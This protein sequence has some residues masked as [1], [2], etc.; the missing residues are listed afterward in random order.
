MIFVPPWAMVGA[1]VVWVQ[2][3]NWR[4]I[5]TGSAS[6]A[7]ENRSGRWPAI[8]LGSFVVVWAVLAISP[9]SREDWLLENMLVFA[10]VPLLALTRHRL[11]FGL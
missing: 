5:P 6:H 2:A 11:R 7:S 10:S 8:L 3:W 1:K 4:P 9:V